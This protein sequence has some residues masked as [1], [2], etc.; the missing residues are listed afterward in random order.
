MSLVSSR[1]D[2]EQNPSGVV[3]DLVFPELR[4]LNVAGPES[5]A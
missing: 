5:L 4:C 1:G 3:V 2:I